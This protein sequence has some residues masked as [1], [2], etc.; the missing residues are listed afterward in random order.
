M[1]IGKHK[2]I[3]KEC[4]QKVWAGASVSPDLVP[5]LTKDFLTEWVETRHVCVTCYNPQVCKVWHSPPTSFCKLNVDV[6][7][8]EDTMKMGIGMIIHDDSGSF[9]SCRS[10]VIPGVFRVDEGEAMSLLEALSWI[11]QLGLQR[12][13]IVVNVLLVADAM[14]NSKNRELVSLPFVSIN[15]ANRTVNE[16]THRVARNLRTFQN[17]NCW[18]ESPI[19]VVGLS[20]DTCFC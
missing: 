13:K 10:L 5:T 6:F 7:F 3:W 12:V 17:L 18:V 15:Y 11:K 16:K 9:V 1:E 8:F 2:G 14:K 20:N 4:N 19:F